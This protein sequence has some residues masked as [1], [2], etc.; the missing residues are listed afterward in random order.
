MEGSAA[1]QSACPCG[2]R[3]RP[4]TCGRRRLV[5]CVERRVFGADDPTTVF[6]GAWDGEDRTFCCPRELPGRRRGYV[7]V[8]PRH[9][10]VV[11]ESMIVRADEE[12]ISADLDQRLIDL[13]L[14]PR[15]Q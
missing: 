2:L 13:A 8:G 11:S 7:Y 1:S 9:T 14:D 4:P 12:P 15:L 3:E 6:V 5:E 10:V